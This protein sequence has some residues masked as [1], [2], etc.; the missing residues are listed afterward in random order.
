[1]GTVDIDEELVVCWPHGRVKALPCLEPDAEVKCLFAWVLEEPSVSSYHDAWTIR[2]IG[3]GSK[4]KVQCG[5]DGKDVIVAVVG[6]PNKMALN[7]Y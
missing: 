4:N 2:P 7:R 5:E 6:L 1:M 3:M